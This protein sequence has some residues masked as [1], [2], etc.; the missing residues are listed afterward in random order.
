[1]PGEYDLER[2][3]RSLL[4]Y[5]YV[6][7]ACRGAGLFINGQVYIG[8]RVPG[9]GSSIFVYLDVRH[10]GQQ[11]DF[12]LGRSPTLHR[13]FSVREQFGEPIEVSS[14]NCGSVEIHQMKDLFS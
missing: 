2:E 11:L 10:S 5:R 9:S 8:R 1:M 12:S 4:K 7:L 6:A 3:F 13:P 14:I